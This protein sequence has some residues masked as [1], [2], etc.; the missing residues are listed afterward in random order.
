MGGI[1]NLKG[2]YFLQNKPTQPKL[3]HHSAGEE[4]Y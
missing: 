3:K 4:V 1:L 2:K